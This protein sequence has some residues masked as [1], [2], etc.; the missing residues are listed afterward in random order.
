MKN[1]IM[2][3][4]GHTLLAVLAHPDDES[5]GMGGT[6]ALY[7]QQGAD[8][9]LV[10]ATR[11]EAGDIEAKDS[12]EHQ[13]VAELRE[14]ELRCASEKLGLKDVHFLGYRD[15]GM[16]GAQDNQHP[17]ALAA[18]PVEKVAVEIGQYI[19]AIRPQVIVTFDPIGGYKH[20][21]HIAV[22]QA[23]IKA[24]H[25]ARSPNPT[26]SVSLYQPQKLYYH[27]IPKG[28]LR[29][30]IRILS[31]MGR[32]PHHFGRNADID[33]VSL[34]KDDNFQ[35]HAKIN[36]RRVASLKDQAALCHSSQVE[37]GSLRQ[38]PL[39]WIQALFGG[40]DHYMRGFPTPGK[41]TMERD[42]F[43]G[44]KVPSSR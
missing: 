28:Y 11:G 16:A 15:S 24:F 13:S 33:L 30:A 21:D 17:R 23:T 42:L 6:L 37:G 12:L 19:R 34:V 31:I 1:K 41:K 9:H 32:D 7:A 22:H 25:D 43:A 4:S 44:I 8:V 5:F 36:Y 26:D 2:D 40:K 14:S 39:K 38:G 29:W 10:C 27:L 18:A 3:Y 35:V 20:P